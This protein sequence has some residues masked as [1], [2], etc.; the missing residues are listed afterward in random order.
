MAQPPTLVFDLETKLL[1]EDVGGWNYVDRLGMAAAVVYEAESNQYHRFQEN[2]VQEL[3]GLLRTAGRVIGYNVR[4][5][6]YLVLKPYGGTDL[7]RLPTIDL[8]EHLYQALGFRLSLDAVASATLGAGKSADGLQAVAWY[9]EGKIDKVLA[10]CQD[11]VDLTWRL[12]QHGR[13]HGEICYRDRSFRLRS[14]PVAW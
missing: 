8:L 5:F 7:P 11:D 6:D 13:R 12:Y 2:E 4:R 14:V 3:L 1:A 10:Y 9:R